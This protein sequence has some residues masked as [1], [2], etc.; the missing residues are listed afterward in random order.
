MEVLVACPKNILWVDIETGRYEVVESGRTEYYGISW[1]RE[2]L[3]F[4]HSNIDN[5]SLGTEESYRNS[6]KGTV[7]VARRTS[8]AFLSQPHQI[9]CNNG[10]VICTNTGRNA[11][12]ILDTQTLEYENFWIND[13]KWDRLGP[14][15]TGN[16]FNSVYVKGGKLYVCAHNWER[17]SKIFIVDLTTK[18]IEKY[19]SMEASLWAH[20]VCRVQGQTL[21]CATNRGQLIEAS[22]GE[23]LCQ[24]EKRVLTRG[25]AISRDL[26][27]MGQSVWDGSRAA[28]NHSDGGIWVLDRK[29]YKKLSFIKLKKSGCVHEIRI[30]TEKDYAHFGDEW[31]DFPGIKTR[32]KI[33]GGN[34]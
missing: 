27:L 8:A 23:I 7:S 31:V 15:G 21:V 16:H 29:S 18:V 10:K 24:A 1:T 20:N 13:K 9:V 3:C 17:P 25:L 2:G 30:T 14:K 5:A 33:Y 4:S 22:S 32:G 6:I 12:G 28:R 34:R 26:I 11:I 19:I